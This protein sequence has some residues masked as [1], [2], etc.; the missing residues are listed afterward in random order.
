MAGY[1]DECSTFDEVRKI[2]IEKTVDYTN[3]KNEE[4]IRL[5]LCSLDALP[6]KERVMSYIKT[7][8]KLCNKSSKLPIILLGLSLMIINK[9]YT[10]KLTDD[11]LTLF[12]INYPTEDVSVSNINFMI[13]L[14]PYEILNTICE[15]TDNVV[16]RSVYCSIFEYSNGNLGNASRKEKISSICD[17]I[18]NIS[19]KKFKELKQQQYEEL[20]STSI[21][22]I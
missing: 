22:S 10:D 5:G 21:K 6:N 12:C 16:D 3:D 14:M 17:K 15:K 11:A 7:V 8:D 13:S 9:E 18:K 20:Y 2:I 1:F 19:D 4:L